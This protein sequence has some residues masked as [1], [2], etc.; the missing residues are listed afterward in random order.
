M[1]PDII[2]VFTLLFS[3]TLR[4]ISCC[5]TITATTTWTLNTARVA[6]QRN[7]L[8]NQWWSY[9]AS[10]G[11]C[12]STS[13]VV[14]SHSVATSWEVNSTLAHRQ[15]P[16]RHETKVHDYCTQPAL[17]IRTKKF[18]AKVAPNSEKLG[19]PHSK[20]GRQVSDFYRASLAKFTNFA[21][22]R[23]IG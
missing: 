13:L 2:N 17:E 18:R 22:F 16:R 21:I 8:W 15:S 9:W 6:R 1:W 4:T 11:T 23:R 3:P 14:C 12:R 19:G 10:A 5:W 20:V 7:W